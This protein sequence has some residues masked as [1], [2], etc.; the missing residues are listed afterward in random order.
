MSLINQIMHIYN[1]IAFKD[2]VMKNEAHGQQAV[3]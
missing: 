1:V 2:D 3:D